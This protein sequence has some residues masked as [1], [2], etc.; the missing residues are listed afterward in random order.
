MNTD[1]WGEF[2]LCVS[3]KALAKIWGYN[4]ENKKYMF[5]IVINISHS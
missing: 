4:S 3:E 5:N 1:K 2:S